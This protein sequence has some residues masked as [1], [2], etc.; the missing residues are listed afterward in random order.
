LTG[1]IMYFIYRA[2][3]LFGF[4]KTWIFQMIK[5]A[6]RILCKYIAHTYIYIY[7][8]FQDFRA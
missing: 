4:D 3:F 8:V 5:R 6:W 2:R 7:R 1:W